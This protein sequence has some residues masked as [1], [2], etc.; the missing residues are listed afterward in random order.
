VLALFTSLLLPT[1]SVA[2]QTTT[3]PAPQ[4]RVAPSAGNAVEILTPVQ[5]VDFNEYLRTL[6]TRVKQQWYAAMPNSVYLGTK[7]IA[8]IVFDIE[9]DGT[10]KNAFVETSSQD[11][12]LDQ[13]AMK[14]IQNAGPFAP[15]P[16][17]FKGP[18]IE[19]RFTFFT[20]SQ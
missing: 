4:A 18:D 17:A 10:I 19:L 12:E 13:A 1:A 11:A 14:G 2:Q 7:G 16:D 9:R 8:K 15:L 5:G 20:T 6:V 3:P